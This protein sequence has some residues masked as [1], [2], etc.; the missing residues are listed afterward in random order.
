MAIPARRYG[1]R[2]GDRPIK[3][4]IPP[5]PATTPAHRTSSYQYLDPMQEARRLTSTN[6][7]KANDSSVE[8]DDN[9]AIEEQFRPS[10][11]RMTI[12]RTDER[13][14]RSPSRDRPE[15]VTIVGDSLSLRN[16]VLPRCRQPAFE[17]LSSAEYTI[18]RPCR[19]FRISLESIR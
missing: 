9:I 18:S 10:T 11:E 6:F 1:T 3:F 17:I 2:V 19:A 16:L 4:G 14:L 5:T 7:G 8:S 12:Q 13:L 15:S